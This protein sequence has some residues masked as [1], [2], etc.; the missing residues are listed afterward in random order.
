MPEETEGRR[1]YGTDS[2]EEFETLAEVTLHED[3]TEHLAVV[4]V[5]MSEGG[6]E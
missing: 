2:T 3:G 6:T 4:Q 5:D 1:A